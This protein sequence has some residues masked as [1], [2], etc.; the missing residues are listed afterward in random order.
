MNLITVKEAAAILN[1]SERTVHNYLDQGKLREYRSEILP[2]A[3]R[4]DEHEV[5][6]LLFFAPKTDS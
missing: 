5:R 1:V 3:V 4:L 6:N 2:R